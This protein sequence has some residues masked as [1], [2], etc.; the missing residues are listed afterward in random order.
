MPSSKKIPVLK[1]RSIFLWI[2]ALCLLQLA[3]SVTLF[4]LPITNAS[5]V[6]E[7]SSKMT[8]DSQLFFGVDS[9]YT[10]DNSAWQHVVP[11]RNKL[12]FPLH[13]SYSSLRWDLLDGPGSLEVD[14]LYVTILGE[15]L[16][17]GNLSLTPLFDIEQMQS[18]G[19]K[20]YITTQVDARDPQIGVTL[21]FEKISKARVLT[22]AL[23]GFFLAL[24]LVALFY[25]RSSAK[26]LIN[27]IDSVILAAA[28]Q[29]RSDGISLKEIGCLIAIGSI[30]YVYFLS[31]FS[32]SI[33]DEMA[34]VRQDPAAWVTQGRWFVYIVEKLIFPQ[35]SIPFAPYAFLVT[36]LAASYALILRAHNYTPD[37]RS[38]ATYPIF[39]AFP[40]WWFISEFYSNI[41]AVAFGI[42]FTSCSAYLVL[43]ENNNDRLKN[44]NHTLKNIS[45]VILLACATAAYQSLI[46]FFIAMVFGTLLT[47]YQRNNCGDGKLL[48]H[49]ATVL[50]KNMLLVLAALGTYIAI[51][52]IAQKIIAADS[53]Y[54]G[55]FINYKA[56]ADHPFDALELVFTEMKLIYTGDSARY[57]TSM[58]LS[59]LL[60]IAST[61]TVLFKS[62]GKIAVPLFLWAGVLTIPFA[63]N[64]VSGGSP[65]PMRTLLAIAYVSWI[66][67]L[68][69]LSNKRPFILSLGVLTVLLYQIQIF[70]TNSQYMVS[71]TITQAH[72]RALAADI[73]RRIGELSNDFDRNAPLEVDVFG[74][75]VITT[76]Y[77]NGWS[78]TMQGSFFSWDDGNVGRMVTYMRVMGYENLTTPA[79]EERIAM[80]PIF[81]EMPVWPAA[82]SVKKIGNRYLVRLSKEPDPTHAK[83]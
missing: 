67:S 6:V 47:R 1:K 36:M 23:L 57:G 72:D 73:Y 30:F 24:F 56:L 68:L 60:I 50:L 18:V 80:T 2:A 71:A 13:G 20:T 22:S 4:F 10:Q 16:N 7:T 65:L 44:G 33:D 41:P 51:N 8:G 43:G 77:A 79:A 15:K 46:L 35:S 78:S 25:F 63:F 55:N 45:V 32:F 14:N 42:F 54:I 11:G 19:A 40:T 74:K 52:M 9:N 27:H 81:T 29:L 21:D 38:Y 49:T 39:C 31:T 17:T 82:G 53:G 64:L 66:A 76:L 58:G 26:K 34:A 37:W 62:H 70:S 69:I 5:L 28:R 3:L 61:L 12:I 59:A 75:K 83:F 48:K